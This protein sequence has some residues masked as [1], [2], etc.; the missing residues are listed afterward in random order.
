MLQELQKCKQDYEFLESTLLDRLDLMGWHDALK[1][2]HEPK[3][4]DEQERGRRRFVFQ[5]IHTTVHFF[6]KLIKIFYLKQIFH[7]GALGI[8]SLI[9][10][11]C[12][13]AMEIGAFYSSCCEH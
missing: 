10:M 4:K 6:V 12:G 5:V 7:K 13:S 3:A 11:E 9:A 1:A 2:M 8:C